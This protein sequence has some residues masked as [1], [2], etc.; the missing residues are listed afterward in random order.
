M[1]RKRQLTRQTTTLALL[2]ENSCTRSTVLL[3]ENLSFDS[4]QNAALFAETLS[5][6]AEVR[7]K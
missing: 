3:T 5:A 4:S 6:I 1:S 2:N 7:I